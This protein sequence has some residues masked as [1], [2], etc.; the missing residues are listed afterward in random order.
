MDTFLDALKHKKEIDETNSFV[1]LLLSLKN[2]F[3]QHIDEL[4]HGNKDSQ[5]RIPP[6]CQLAMNASG[7]KNVYVFM[8]L[9]L[10]H[11]SNHSFN[12]M[13]S[14]ATSSLRYTTVR[15]YTGKDVD[16]L[17][18]IGEINEITTNIR[19]WRENVD[20]RVIDAALS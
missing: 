18:W 20:R 12:C 16:Y 5:L 14:Y 4:S 3:E 13:V 11:L 7:Q 6:V 10:S 15:S 2:A 8:D 19:E 17:D 9:L 1:N